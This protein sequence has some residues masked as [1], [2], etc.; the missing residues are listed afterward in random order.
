M[1][2]SPTLKKSCVVIFSLFI[3]LF[4]LAPSI[5]AQTCL[6]PDNRVL[7]HIP[8]GN[9]AVFNSGTVYYYF[10]N[11]P[12]GPEKTQIITAFSK[13]NAALGGPTNC[14]GVFFSQGPPADFSPILRI[15]N[16]PLRLGTAAQT[17]YDVTFGNVTQEATITINPDV[18]GR[19]GIRFFNPATDGFDTA[20]E[21]IVLHEVGHALGLN[22][23][24]TG[25]PDACGT[26]TPS[27]ADDQAHGSSVMNDGC[28]V[29]D[30][31]NNI[32]TTVTLCDF[33]QVNLIY[34]C[35][36]PTPSP[37]PTPTLTPTPTP[38]P[39]PNPPGGCNGSPNYGQYTSGCAP[40]FIYNGQYCTRSDVFISHCDLWSGYDPD[41]CGCTGFCIP[42]LGGCSPIVVDILGN[43]FAMTSGANGVMFDL[44]A[45]GTPRQFSWTASGSDDAWLALDRNG[46]DLIDSGKEL[47]GNITPQPPPP[48]GEE[49]NGFRALA[50]YDTAGFGG[51]GDG[52]IAQQDAIFNRL[53]LWRDTNH[54]GVSEPG[55]LFTLPDLGLRKIDLD[56][57]QSRR[58]D[59]FGNQFKY[60]A[61]VRDAQDAQLGRWAWDVFL[62]VPQ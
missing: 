41:A 19:T 1:L 13:W 62:V 18:T 32:S 45:S 43:G 50:E 10:E 11:V 23:Y 49:M 51:N 14:S 4:L 27:T 16:G 38:T 26:N 21:K 58:V 52:K 12:D 46:D 34:I 42:E 9:P 61:K 59:E 5:R 8:Q 54:N 6:V 28:Q 25:H 20:F 33:A 56:Y 3:A 22:H 15:R 39:T 35:P 53:R 47:F 37:S 48:D 30:R 29:N 17:D 7:P 36:I 40:G 31:T 57:R 44:E 55:E 24:T 2:N 60:R